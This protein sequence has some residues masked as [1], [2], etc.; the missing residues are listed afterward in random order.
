MKIFQQ[1]GIRI[2]NLNYTIFKLITL[3]SFMDLE[4]HKI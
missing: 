3:S 4:V 1:G 2:E